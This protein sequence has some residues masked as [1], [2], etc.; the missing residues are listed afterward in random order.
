MRFLVFLLLQFLLAAAETGTAQ[1]V[2]NVA[3]QNIE[4]VD[5]TT[6]S[7][8]TYTN[9]TITRVEPNGIT[10]FHVEG[11]V[12]IPFTELPKELQTKYNY[13]PTNAAAYTRA[14]NQKQAEAWERQQANIKKQ[15]EQAVVEAAGKEPPKKQAS[16][17]EQPP[18]DNVVEKREVT[19]GNVYQGYDMGAAEGIWKADPSM[20][21]KRK[22]RHIGE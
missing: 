4:R 16:N 13:N 11:I 12:K 8:V 18:L 21:G 22:H 14:V 9:C 1:D 6:R 5:I 7:G 19:P 2:V 15:R 10:V 20:L 3:T 17:K